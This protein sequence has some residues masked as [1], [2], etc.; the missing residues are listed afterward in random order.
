MHFIDVPPLNESHLVGFS[1]L[2]HTKMPVPYPD[3]S[4]RYVQYIPMLAV[5]SAFQGKT[6]DDSG[7]KYS[8]AIMEQ[9]VA[10]ASML[11]PKSWCLQVHADN[12]RAISLYGQFGFQS[13]G[14]PD[15]RN[16]LRMLKRLRVRIFAFRVKSF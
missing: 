6:I 7:R 1:S 11:Q 15:G 4:R 13:I 10:A 12:L 3:G 9:I 8:V 2:G 16:M 5:A 14:E